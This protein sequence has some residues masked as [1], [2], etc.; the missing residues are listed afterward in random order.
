M[1]GGQR[2]RSRFHRI[3]EAVAAPGNRLESIGRVRF[4]GGRRVR[5][6]NARRVWLER[7]LQVWL[8]NAAQRLAAG[9]AQAIGPQ[10][11]GGRFLLRADKGVQFFRMPVK[12]QQLM[13]GSDEFR[14]QQRR[15]LLGGAAAYRSRKSLVW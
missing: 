11:A 9:N 5:L 8:E 4:N 2:G 12:G 10:A 6:E 13:D 7:D 14:G 15:I 1:E 3:I